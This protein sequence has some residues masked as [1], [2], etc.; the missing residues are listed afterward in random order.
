MHRQREDKYTQN[1][2]SYPARRSCDHFFRLVLAFLPNRL[3]SYLPHSWDNACAG[4]GMFPLGIFPCQL[5]S[6]LLPP[7]APE[8][9]PVSSKKAIA[10]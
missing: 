9:D 7:Q 10:D 5:L 4:G 2:C 3:I 1:G 8:E 6:K